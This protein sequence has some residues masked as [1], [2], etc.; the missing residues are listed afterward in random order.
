MNE[1]EKSVVDTALAVMRRRGIPT[2]RFIEMKRVC[3]VH[4]TSYAAVYREVNGRWKL[5]GCIRALSDSGT[6]SGGAKMVIDD[7]LI[8]P[9]NGEICPWCGCGPKIVC[10]TEAIFVRCGGCK[11]S[12]CLGR[13]SGDTFKCCDQC[14]KVSRISGSV[15]KFDAWTRGS[16]G[17]GMLTNPNSPALLGP[18]RLQ[19]TAGRK[20]R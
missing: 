7:S 19:L 13:T 14:G 3:A 8:D 18:I 15:S 20:G 4:G 6:R 12:V 10:G 5:E 1:K 9:N 11:N 16:N 2:D 17:R